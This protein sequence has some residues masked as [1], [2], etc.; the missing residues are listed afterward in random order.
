M[1]PNKYFAVIADCLETVE[2]S[3]LAI[4]RDDVVL[5]PQTTQGKRG[6][7][8]VSK[9]GTTEKG[10]VPLEYLRR[11]DGEQ[12]ERAH[13]EHERFLRKQRAASPKQPS[14]GTAAR[15]PRQGAAS[16]ADG[17]PA[18]RSPPPAAQDKLQPMLREDTAAEAEAEE[19]R[20][21]DEDRLRQAQ[22][23]DARVASQEAQYSQQQRD[24]LADARIHAK[25]AAVQPNPSGAALQSLSALS[26]LCAR[27]EDRLAAIGKAREAAYAQLEDA[28][29]DVEG[30]VRLAAERNGEVSR[31][32]AELDEMIEAER[33][34]W[35]A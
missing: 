20:R 21:R 26:E 7:L 11:L 35:S 15:S 2:T 32:L 23:Q 13:A 27:H 3:E 30:R 25:A 12:E 19:K 9:L 34:K 4:R 6:W 31:R 28:M 29:T 17:R 14:P 1:L 22:R 18:P 33:A 5:A 10:F 24:G 16:T 8:H